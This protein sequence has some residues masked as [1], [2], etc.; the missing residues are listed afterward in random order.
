MQPKTTPSP[1]CKKTW[2]T[3][4]T[5]KNY[6]KISPKSLRTTRSCKEKAE[7]KRIATRRRRRKKDPPRKKAKQPRKSKSKRLDAKKRRQI[8][9]PRTR[10]PTRRRR[11]AKKLQKGKTKRKNRRS[12]QA[13]KTCV[14]TPDPN[15]LELPDNNADEEDLRGKVIRTMKLEV[16]NSQGEAAEKEKHP[17]LDLP[18]GGVTGGTP[19][20]VSPEL[21]LVQDG[22]TREASPPAEVAATETHG[23]PRS[24]KAGDKEQQTQKDQRPKKVDRLGSGD[25]EDQVII[26]ESINAS[27]AT[28][29]RQAL[30]ESDA[31]IQFVQ[32]TCLTTSLQT[33]FDKEAKEFHKR[34]MGSPLDPE[35]SKAT[36]GV[37]VV[38]AKGFTFYQIPN[39]TE[40]Y[41]DA[42]KTGR[43]NIFCVDI[44]GQTLACANV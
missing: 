34:V 22:P 44:A 24:T 6:S 2:S 35:H 23:I 38:A 29:N 7:K 27:S 4:W 10:K 37:D 42:E 30:L 33:A 14:F 43:C 21:S 28:V 25:G 36:A 13:K 9:A 15:T 20:G 8:R 1:T 11:K 16:A 32:E 39:P 41:K 31:H 5:L 18:K 26:I 19:T 3:P 40:D 12:G 17:V